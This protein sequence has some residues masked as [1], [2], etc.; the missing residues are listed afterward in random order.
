MTEIF[1]L[2]NTDG[3]MHV[4][5]E[6]LE[7]TPDTCFCHEL[8]FSLDSFHQNFNYM[9]N[10]LNNRSFDTFISVYVKN[11]NNAYFPWIS[12]TTATSVKF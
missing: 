7:S 10:I 4:I 8:F 5:C 3:E 12:K 1:Q 6:K 11:N 2:L 9:N